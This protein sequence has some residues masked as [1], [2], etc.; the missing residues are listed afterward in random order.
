MCNK[1]TGNEPALPCGMYGQQSTTGLTIRQ[2]LAARAMQGLLASG[3]FT[4]E[5]AQNQAL[6][7]GSNIS[8]AIAVSAVDLADE[9][10]TA[11]NL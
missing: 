6:A 1:I 3:I 5:E 8:Q 4:N 11:L 2:E 7:A 10:I 9:L